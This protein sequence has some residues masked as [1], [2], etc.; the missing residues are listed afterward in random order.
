VVRVIKIGTVSCEPTELASKL[1]QQIKS[2]LGIGGGSTVTLI[3]T[4]HLILVDT[5]FD[6]EWLDTPE[7]DERNATGLASS[8][9]YLGLMAEDIDAV[10]ITHW[11]EDHFGNL[12]IFHRAER[13]ALKGMVER[14][15]LHDYTKVDDEE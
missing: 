15:G 1:T 5:G 4:G 7:N 13:L 6:R 14:F 9:G 12:G 8:L 2:D 3:Q 10:F 11:H